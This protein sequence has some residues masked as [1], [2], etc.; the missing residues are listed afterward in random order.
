MTPRTVRLL[1]GEHTITM[2][3]DGYEE[4]TKTIRLNGRQQMGLMASLNKKGEQPR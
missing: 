2:I 1:A 4:W 3:A